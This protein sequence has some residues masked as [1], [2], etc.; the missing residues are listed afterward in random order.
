[1]PKKF[2]P[3]GVEA[4]EAWVEKQ[5]KLRITCP[6]IRRCHEVKPECSDGYECERYKRELRERVLQRSRMKSKPYDFQRADVRYKD[7]P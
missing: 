7:L 3:Y 1:M 2:N 6:E 4:I 5:K